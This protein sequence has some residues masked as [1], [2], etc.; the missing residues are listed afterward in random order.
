MHSITPGNLNF[1]KKNREREKF[2]PC[3]CLSMKT[4]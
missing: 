1:K 2:D 3:K 4:S